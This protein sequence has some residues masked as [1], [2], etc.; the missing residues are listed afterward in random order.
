MLIEDS[1]A[2]A[3]VITEVL[4]RARLSIHVSVARDGEEAVRYLQWLRKSHWPEVILLDLG[5]PKTS[6]MEVLKWVRQEA[7]STIPIIVITCTEWPANLAEIT[8]LG[9]TYFR[10]PF[11]LREYEELPKLVHSV[12][13]EA[14]Q[15][16]QISS[17]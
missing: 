13:H 7:Q 6:G 8:A 2:D 12:C 16:R 11:T 5:L 1:A 15:T 3:F 4:D 9:G 17:V 14:K 10:K